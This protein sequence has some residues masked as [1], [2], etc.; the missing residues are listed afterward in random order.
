MK[1]LI[2][3]GGISGLSAAW[4]AK[5]EFP[6][7]EITLLEASGRVGG[8]IATKREEGFYFELG[9]RTFSAARTPR[10]Q[11][12]LDS[13]G[14]SDQLVFSEKAAEKRF[15]YARGCLRSLSSF[16]PQLLYAGVRDLCGKKRENFA[17]EETVAAF[18]RRRFSP[19]IASSFLDAIS[20]GVYATPAE[21][22]SVSAAFP[23]LW[24]AEREHRSIL[25]T[26]FKK[27]GGAKGLFTLSGGMQT[28]VD[29]LFERLQG[30]IHCN[31]AVEKIE[32][33]GVWA[34]G[35]FWPADRVISALSL[36]A[37]QRIAELPQEGLSSVSF[38]TATFLLPANAFLPK[39]Y[40]YLVP[41]LEGEEVMGMVW[42]TEIFPH[43]SQRG[44][45]VTVFARGKSP[46]EAAQRALQTHLGFSGQPLYAHLE[47]YP[48]ALPHFGLGFRSR[49]EGFCKTAFPGVLFAGAFAGSPSVEGCIASA[50][51]ALYS[52]NF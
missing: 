29:A 1:L 40:G 49:I 7:A 16:W 18:G 6:Q 5:R 20:L 15:L 43:L 38:S 44:K 33:G 17:E 48:D 35:R 50:E 27:K 41:S 11:A 22:L 52:I 8:K 24:E 9:P 12:L 37:L 31:T 46:L 13:L 36:P 28:L 42:E 10:L 34:G 47:R 2:L 30:S 21:E 26:R 23:F 14:L 45:L 3:G 19:F 39:G 51:A 4:L 32:R 25:L